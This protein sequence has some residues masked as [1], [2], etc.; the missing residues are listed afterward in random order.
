MFLFAVGLGE[1]LAF[2]SIAGAALLL[3]GIALLALAAF[4]PAPTSDRDPFYSTLFLMLALVAALV[5]LTLGAPDPVIAALTEGA[6]L[7]FL[8]TGVVVRW[9][10]WRLWI[11]AAML[12]AAHG[13]FLVHNPYPQHQDVFRFLNL[14]VDALAQG[15]NPYGQAASSVFRYTYPPGILLLSLPFRVLAGDV[16]WAY[17]ASEAVVVLFL[18]DLCQGEY[19][20]R[21]RWQDA[22]IL[23]PLA[24]PRT[25]QAFYIFGN[26]EW[27]LLAL[28]ALALLLTRRGMWLATGVML[29]VGLASKQYFVVFPVL[30]LF[31]YFDRR[32]LLFALLVALVIASPFFA[33]DMSAFV[34]HIFGNAGLPPDPERITVWAMLRS[35]GIVLASPGQLALTAAGSVAVLGLAVWGW[36]SLPRALMACGL[37]LMI[38]PLCSSSSAY[39]YFVYALV[40]Y[41]WG[42]V[43]AAREPAAAPGEEP[44]AEA[45]RVE[46]AA[47]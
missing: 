15:V 17:V 28:A 5:Q 12:I 27:V 1:R 39:N 36:K 10:P 43:L 6:A 2:Y 8:L 18:G 13:V 26:H 45:G 20:S 25:S 37:G 19:R 41:T 44:A 29:G 3:A 24:L 35:G 11:C 22:L 14:G 46:T 38:F 7:F 9:R 42:V 40:F 4:R 47:A 30:F 32:S 21:L 16:R 33:W 34:E 23:L 31:R